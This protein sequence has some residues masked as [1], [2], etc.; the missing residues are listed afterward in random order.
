[1]KKASGPKIIQICGIRGIFLALFIVMCLFA[2]FVV[3]PAKLAM[4]AWNYVA[5]K[6]FIFPEINL[7]Q[8]AL[9]WG[10]V[11]LGTYLLNDRQLAISF[12][13]PKE[14]SDD[15]MKT[16]MHRV[17]TQKAAEQVDEKLL[18]K[19]PATDSEGS[20]SKEEVLK[21]DE[22]FVENSSD[23]VSKS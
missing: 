6:Y 21:P 17:R 10:F 5:D 12:H 1:M 20:D 16:L 7:F 23:T 14:L 8:G 3:F 19:E 18:N 11:A 9:L 13:Q 4:L 2:G 22:T 15:E